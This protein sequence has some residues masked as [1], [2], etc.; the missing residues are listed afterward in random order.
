MARQL[1][2]YYQDVLSEL[3]VTGPDNTSS[4]EDLRIVT[5]AYP[6]LWAMLFERQLVGWGVDDAIPDMALL[7]MRWIAAFHLAPIFGVYG[8]KLAGLQEKGQLE[9][10]RPS[11]GER[12]LRKQASPDAISNTL[13]VEYY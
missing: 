12:V 4:A 11:L 7:P 1:E 5:D 6:S 2:N 13:D 9:G 10:P 8:Q 3:G